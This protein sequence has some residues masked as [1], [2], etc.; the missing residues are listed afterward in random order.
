M[1]PRFQIFLIATLFLTGCTN[2]S[3]DN[4]SNS[5]DWPAVA[6]P[7]DVNII[8]PRLSTLHE[9]MPKKRVLEIL[10]LS[11]RGP[12]AGSSGLELYEYRL[13][14]GQTLSLMFNAFNVSG[15]TAARFM[16]ASIQ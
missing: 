1:K 15:S 8:R 14:N 10:G 11:D 9:G 2:S 16:D 13:S 7:V 4:E 6:G 5:R 3:H 12:I